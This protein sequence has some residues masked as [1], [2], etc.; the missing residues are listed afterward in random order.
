[1]AISVPHEFL[2]ELSPEELKH[3][4]ESA[5]NAVTS[6]AVLQIIS[7]AKSRKLLNGSEQPVTPIIVKLPDELFEQ[8]RDQADRIGMEHKKYFSLAFAMGARLSSMNNLL[9]NSSIR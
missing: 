7:G 8:F 4:S 2:A 3:V 9:H 1:M 6:K 5:N